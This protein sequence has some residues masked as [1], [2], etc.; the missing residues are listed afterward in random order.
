MWTARTIL[1]EICDADLRR[2]V[3]TSFWKH[4]DAQGKA[5]A[6]ALLAKAMKFREESMR[7]LPREKKAEMLAARLGNP[8]FDQFYDVALM[9]YHTAD[10]APMLGAFLDKWGIPHENGS[11]EAEEYATPTIEQ[12][13]EA[14]KELSPE[15]GAPNV[16]LYLATAGLLMG[17]DW[18]AVTWPVVDELAPKG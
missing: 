10:M 8:D 11:I 13:R 14:A 18:A 9:Q 2:D 3:L 4:A 5:L 15:Y 12:V 7:K 17:E 16:R 6:N 1:K